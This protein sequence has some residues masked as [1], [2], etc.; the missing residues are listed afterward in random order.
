MP[1]DRET[2]VRVGPSV[3]RH[4]RG[5]LDGMRLLVIGGVPGSAYEPHP[6]T[7]LGGPEEIGE[8]ATG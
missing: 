6:V 2:W 8:G 3:K 5:G 1:L 7:E 4:V